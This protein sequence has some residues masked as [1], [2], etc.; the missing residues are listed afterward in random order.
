MIDPWSAAIKE[1]YA[2]APSGEV[3]WPTLELRHPTLPVPARIVVDHG[4]KLGDDPLVYGRMLRIEADAPVDAGEVVLFVSCNLQAV[5]PANEENQG[6]EMTLSIDNVPGDLMEALNN[7]VTTMAP[8]DVVYRE[9]MKDDP[10]TVHFMLEG[11][12][13]SR[14]TANMFRI[15]GKAGFLDLFNR[16]FLVDYS[17]EEHPSLA[18]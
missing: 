16:Q 11:M 14:V 2:S 5:P 7:A 15:E 1:A 13:L 8:I 4:E 18:S 17:A 3:I 6:P 10:D 9:Y 12:T